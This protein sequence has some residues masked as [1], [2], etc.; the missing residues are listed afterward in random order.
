MH[1]DINISMS[2]SWTSLA[3]LRLEV[4]LVVC[5][6]FCF[7]LVI[8]VG[9]CCY[10][11]CHYRN[12][13][14]RRRPKAVGVYAKAVGV[15]YADG[16][17]RRMEGAGQTTEKA[18]GVY[19]ALGV[20]SVRRRPP[21]AWKMPSAYTLRKNVPSIRRRHGRRH[22]PTAYFFALRPIRRRQCR[23]HRSFLYSLFYIFYFIN[24]S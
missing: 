1:G 23:R 24:L 5:F 21:S 8:R 6:Y 16:C 4:L 7:R 10:A 22:R 17:R 19:I 18:L 11:F 13:T 9:C 14:R 15:A 3:E 20:Y 2:F 12:T